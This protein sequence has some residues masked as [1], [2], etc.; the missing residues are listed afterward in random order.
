[1]SKDSSWQNRPYKAYSLLPATVDVAA[2]IKETAADCECEERDVEDVY[3][4]TPLQAGL[5]ISTLKSAAA[6]ICH[7]NY[8]IC[9][10]TDIERLRFSWDQLIATEH[11]LRN[12]IIWN[13]STQS[14]FQATIAHYSSGRTGPGLKSTMALGDNLC[15]A[16]LVEDTETQR[17]TLELSI[18]HSIFDGWSI[19][20]ILQ[21]LKAIYAGSPP[22]PGL[23]FTSFIHHLA[24]KHAIGCSESQEFWEQYLSGASVLNFPP[25]PSNIDHEIVTDGTRSIRSSLDIESLTSKYCVSP[26]T[27]LYAASAIVLGGLSDR[28]DVTFGLTLSG[29]DVFLSSI[30]EM[31]GPAIA[32]VPFRT[33]PDPNTTVETFLQEIQAQV[34]EIIPFQHHGLQNIRRISADTE[35][36]CRFRTLITVQPKNQFIA[37]SELFEKVRI[38]D[39]DLIDNLPLSIEV[40]PEEGHLLLNC[41]F[42][43]ACLSEGE[44]DLV[45]SH[46]MR[47]L[48]ALSYATS[49]SNLAQLPS[50]TGL[51]TDRTR[52]EVHKHQDSSTLPSSSDSIA[53]RISISRIP[54]SDSE[55]QVEEIFQQVF[56]ITGRLTINTNFFELGGDSFTAINVTVAARKRG[57]ILSVGQ[58]YQNPFLGDLAALAEAAP[59]ISKSDTPDEMCT[60]ASLST[61]DKS[62]LLWKE[63]ARLCCISENEIEDVYPASTFQED[64]AATS[65]SEIPSGDCKLY[66]ATIVLNIPQQTDPERLRGA[67]NSI[68][69]QN[70]I[71]RTRLIHSSHGTMQVVTKYF[72]SVCYYA[73]IESFI[74][75]WLISDE[76]QWRTFQF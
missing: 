75:G 74:H 49:T 11:V 51:D 63:A 2:I 9:Q 1:M 31:V 56:Q 66:V 60:S 65:I 3:P 14:L 18:H 8:K 17:W 7:F 36:G 35:A 54:E 55:L 53:R 71:L 73:H 16:R 30:E 23:P 59:K 46:L 12:R 15:R 64:L 6:Y 45:L 40:V 27:V 47:V 72:S 37:D 20:L 33:H 69:A 22:S 50:T 58:I 62:Q 10:D 28:N 24:S 21:K 43:T 34:L 5:M 61:T 29:R 38:A 13:H 19:R 32:T 68:L 48:E 67:V 52:S 70:P 44:V 25:L 4:C 26:A 41:S 42:Q 39:Y 76:E 57:Y